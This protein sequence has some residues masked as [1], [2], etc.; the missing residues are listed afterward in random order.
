MADNE[1]V[2]KAKGH[3]VLHDWMINDLELEKNEIIIFAIIYGFSHTENQ[4]F[5]GSLQYLAAWTQNTKRNVIRILNSLV[6][7]GYIGKTEQYMNGVKHCKYYTKYVPKIIAGDKL[8][9]VVTKCHVS[10][11]KMSPCSDNLSFDTSIYNIGYSIEDNR[12]EKT[13]PPTQTPP[14]LYEE[15][16]PY[17]EIL[18]AYHTLCPSLPKVQK[19]SND[20]KKAVKARIHDGFT[21]E[22]M[23]QAFIN[24]EASP[25][26]TGKV[27]GRDGRTFKANFDWIMTD[28]YFVK[29]LEDKYAEM[30][31]AQQKPEPEKQNPAFNPYADTE[32]DGEW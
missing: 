8:S 4:Y 21:V 6:A 20:R 3:V 11:D 18:E 7:K 23:K 16:I 24:A 12:E 10:D 5:T 28:K 32:W 13:P 17:S 15:K 31:P 30:K 9:P 19:L 29:V 1:K 14:T 2:I 27:A 26:L 22:Q 25:F